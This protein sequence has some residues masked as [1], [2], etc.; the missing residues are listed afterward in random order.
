[1]K[2]FIEKF[3]RLEYSGN[4]HSTND[5]NDSNEEIGNDYRTI[6]PEAE[7]VEE[8]IDEPE[9]IDLGIDQ[10]LDIPTAIDGE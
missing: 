1:M 5:T 3:Y 6:T 8:E 4:L 7:D 9:Q 2:Q 10:N